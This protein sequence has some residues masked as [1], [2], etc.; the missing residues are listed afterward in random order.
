MDYAVNRECDLYFNIM[1]DG[2][3]CGLRSGASDICLGQTSYTFKSRL[4]CYQEPRVFFVKGRGL[5]GLALRVFAG[6]LFSPMKVAPKPQVFR[7]DQSISQPTSPG[8]PLGKQPQ[9]PP[10]R[11]SP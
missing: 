4:G 8:R 11:N 9:Q 7:T 6:V 10:D 1:Y 2:L 3:D 5:P